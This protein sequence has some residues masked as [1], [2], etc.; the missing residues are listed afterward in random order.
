MHQHVFLPGFFLPLLL[1][2]SAFP[3]KPF[4]SGC[5]AGLW[6]FLYP[7]SLLGSEVLE[8]GW[9]AKGMEV[10]VTQ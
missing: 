6:I 1:L 3:D 4:S 9:G 7:Q 2:V 8:E 5:N 10:S